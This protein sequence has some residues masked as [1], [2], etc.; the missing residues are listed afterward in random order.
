MK[1]AIGINNSSNQ[2]IEDLRNS[3]L[4]ATYVMEAEDWHC[5]KNLFN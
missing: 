3:Q 1:I 2:I 4:F 5:L